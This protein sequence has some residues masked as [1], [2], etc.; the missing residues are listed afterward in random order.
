MSNSSNRSDKINLREKSSK[1]IN[2]NSNTKINT[3]KEISQNIKNES[4]MKLD[5]I[6]NKD[7][8]SKMIKAKI[9]NISKRPA[10]MKNKLH[11]KKKSENVLKDNFSVEYEKINNLCYNKV[12]SHDGIIKKYKI[13]KKKEYK[14]NQIKQNNLQFKNYDKLYKNFV[15]LEKKIKMKIIHKKKEAKKGKDVEKELNEKSNGSIENID[16]EKKY[17]LGCLDVKLILSNN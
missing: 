3:N 2:K 12:N 11:Q 15:D 14:E 10:S 13:N 17:F 16:F 6:N 1:K 4:N 9:M 5:K 8:K 7:P